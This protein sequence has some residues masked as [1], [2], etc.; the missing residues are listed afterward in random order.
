MNE[1]LIRTAEPS[2]AEVIHNAHM[3]SIRE[4]CSKNYR[5]EQINA[6]GGRNFNQKKYDHIFSNDY[7]W[8]A[9]IK[10]EVVGFCH[11]GN[12]SEETAELFGLYL[13]PSAI[14]KGAGKDLLAK[15]VNKA[16]ELGV[17]KILTHSTLTALDF[18]KSQGFKENGISKN[19]VFN[20]VEVEAV[21]MELLLA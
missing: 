17:A 3:K 5:E 14:G 10:D 4:V 12:I 16:N 13:V 15:A 7:L 11:L 8:V 1:V 18:Y 21:G 6:W 2:E 9:V 20:G 19:S